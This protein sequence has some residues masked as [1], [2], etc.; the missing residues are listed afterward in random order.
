MEGAAIDIR[1]FHWMMDMF[2]SIDVGVVVLDRQY[3]V[4]VWNSFMA[5]HSGVR[6][7]EI[8]GKNM[9]TVFD[10]IPVDWFKRK[11][12]SVFLLKSRAFSTWDQRP[13]LIKFKNY[14]PITGPA[15]HMYQNITY[16]PLASAS[17]EVNHVGVIIY[18]VTD[19]AV[20]KIELEH[21][22]DKLQTL[23]R[24]DRLTQLYNR[25]F[26]EDCLI[27]EFHRN[28]RT[29]QPATLIMFDIDHFK[30]VNDTYGHQAGDEVI[31]FTAD[32]IREKIRATDIA[33]RYGGEEFGIVLINTQAE[34]ALYLAERLRKHIQ[35]LTVKHDDMEIRYTISLGIAELTP[36]VQDYKQWIESADQALYNAKESGRNR[37]VVFESKD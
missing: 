37:A 19:I 26:W 36:G 15:E 24:T 31:R 34:G 3:N 28:K 21:A 9:F 23:S 11:T 17:G 22:N 13:Y 30:K 33:G 5:N 10:N 16:I 8:I 7:T 4:L 27:S 14:R 32:S 12:E 18:D 20:N 2:Q 6:P 35:A 1:E 29:Q 25:G